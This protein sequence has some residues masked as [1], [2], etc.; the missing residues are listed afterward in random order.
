MDQTHEERALELFDT[1]GSNCSQAVL[2]V[3][4]RETGLDQDALLKIAS[5]L[6]GGMGRLGGLC[7]AL[8]GACIAYGLIKGTPYWADK[9]EKE[10]YYVDIRDFVK[11]FETKMAATDCRDLSELI[12]DEKYLMRFDGDGFDGARPCAHIV[13]YA[14]GMVKELLKS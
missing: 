10:K 7:G 4:E 3:F 14:V 1:K 12:K 2:A 6:G 13:V 5:P 8:A 11:K 9:N